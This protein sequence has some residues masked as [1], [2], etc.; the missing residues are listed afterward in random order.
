MNEA[1][2]NIL[3]RRSVRKFSDRKIPK[4]ELD[5]IIKAGLYAPSAMNRQTWQF[6]VL[7]KT[8]DIR[9]LAKAVEKQLGREGYDMYEPT[10]LIIPSNAKDSKFGRDDNA[11]ALENI[12]LAASSLGIGSVWINQLHG[13]CD[14]PEIRALLDKYGIPADHVVFGMAALGYSAETEQRVVERVGKVVIV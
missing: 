1:I 6:T 10:A 3:E 13:I 11:C 5:I 4:E 7:T 8:E 14:E 9:E 2:K 12:F